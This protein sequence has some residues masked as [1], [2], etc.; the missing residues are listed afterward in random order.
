MEKKLYT[1]LNV[2]LSAPNSDGIATYMRVNTSLLA[3]SDQ[4]AVYNMVLS[5]YIFSK[6]EA[7]LIN[8]GEWS[9]DYEDV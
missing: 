4:E 5:G 2:R 1:E 9:G 3:K 7:N 6:T 8:L